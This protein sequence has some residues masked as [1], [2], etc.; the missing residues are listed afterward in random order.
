MK[1]KKTENLNLP[2]STKALCTLQA[3]SEILLLKA[4]QR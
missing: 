3:K 2:Y 1:E 4:A